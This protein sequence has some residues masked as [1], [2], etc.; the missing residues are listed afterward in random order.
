[1]LTITSN[2]NILM[3]FKQDGLFQYEVAYA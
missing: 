2:H 1:M 3:P